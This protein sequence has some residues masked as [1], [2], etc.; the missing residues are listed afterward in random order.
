M[1]STTEI[2]FGGLENEEDRWSVFIFGLFG[3]LEKINGR[4]HLG[5]EINDPD[6]PGFWPKLS[7][8]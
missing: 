8:C 4:D 7:K 2:H 1:R 5:W 6:S 3:K